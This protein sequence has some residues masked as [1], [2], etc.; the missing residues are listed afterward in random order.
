MKFCTYNSTPGLDRYLVGQRD[1]VWRDAHKELMRTDTEY[2]R[3]VRRFT[4]RI[5]A[6]TLVYVIISPAF[7]FLQHRLPDNTAVFT[8]SIVVPIAATLVYAFFVLHTSF[9]IQRF[10]N[11]KVGRVLQ[12]R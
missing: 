11:E 7:T 1:R 10:Q 2:R 8:I 9:G 4:V 12:S 6:A 3:A 5:I